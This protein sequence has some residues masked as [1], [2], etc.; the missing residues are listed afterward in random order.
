MLKIES[1]FC[2]LK[3]ESIFMRV[4]FCKHLIDFYPCYAIGILKQ[5]AHHRLQ[6]LVVQAL[7][8]WH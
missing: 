6:I 7:V 5:T 4:D 8:S 2:E 1:I 3:I